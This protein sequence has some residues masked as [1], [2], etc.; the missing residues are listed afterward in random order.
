VCSALEVVVVDSALII[1]SGLGTF[2]Y[3]NN[4]FDC[5]V[6]KLN[7][8]FSTRF[9]LSMGGTNR[10]RDCP[11]E[12]NV[13]ALGA[14]AVGWAWAREGPPG[15]GTCPS[16][17]RSPSSRRSRRRDCEVPG[18]MG[19]KRFILTASP[20]TDGRIISGGLLILSESLLA[21]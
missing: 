12:S 13:H 2:W 9:L 3:S 16:C 7:S 8:N 19:R 10:I 6:L 5:N 4:P 11:G 15:P 20:S 18:S 17:G 1:L 14:A 21:F